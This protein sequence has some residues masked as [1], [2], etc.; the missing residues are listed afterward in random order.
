MKKGRSGLSGF[1]EIYIC[2]NNEKTPLRRGVVEMPFLG[3]E[4][5][6]DLYLVAPFIVY[7]FLP[8]FIYSL[9]PIF[10]SNKADKL[11]DT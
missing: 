3:G 9:F 6:G 10:I 1:Q 8:I 11:F 4:G 5:R 2:F 7:I